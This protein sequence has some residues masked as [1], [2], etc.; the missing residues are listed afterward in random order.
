MVVVG[1]EDEVRKGFALAEGKRFGC[2]KTVFS[3]SLLSEHLP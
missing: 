2:S 1:D 3:F